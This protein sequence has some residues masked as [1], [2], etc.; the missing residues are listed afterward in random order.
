M[1]ISGGAKPSIQMQVKAGA[2]HIGTAAMRQGVVSDVDNAVA[3]LLAGEE[4]FVQQYGRIV[5]D[6]RRGVQEALQEGE[7]TS[8]T[9]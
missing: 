9:L 2:L 3:R 4:V 1:A 8:R 5:D 6:V 7:A